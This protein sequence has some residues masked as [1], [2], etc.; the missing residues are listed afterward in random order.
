MK[1]VFTYVT[2][3]K[4][5]SFIKAA[6]S[7]RIS[8]ATL[9]R[10]IQKLEQDLDAPLIKRNSKGLALTKFGQILYD[11]FYNFDDLISCTK[12]KIKAE[13]SKLLGDIRILIAL[14]TN[15]S[16]DFIAQALI[17]FSEKN[18][19]IKIT[20]DYMV[21]EYKFLED[22]YD[23][24]ITD[25]LPNSVN[26][27]VIKIC[28]SKL[29]LACSRFYIN[30]YGTP[31]SISEIEDKLIITNPNF[32]L[33]NLYELSTNKLVSFKPN[34]TVISTNNSNIASDLVNRSTFIGIIPDY[35][36]STHK[37]IKVLPDYYSH[38][39]DYYL[40]RTG[41]IKEQKI[42]LLIESI[43]FNVRSNVGFK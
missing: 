4:S 13:Q 34:K 35:E 40:F 23:I 17:S 31:K 24:V 32:P 37:L 26:Q 29:V 42:N 19:K 36:V 20:I 8:A 21:R 10:K 33:N 41:S 14:P 6:N 22:Q 25:K 2:L 38:N 18:P 12:Q 16:N 11:S 30:L 39:I 1:D 15:M 28:S 3:V 9:T 27:K 43:L 5:G 7:L